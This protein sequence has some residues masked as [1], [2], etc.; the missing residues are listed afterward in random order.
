MREQWIH[1]T[2]AIILTVEREGNMLGRTV[3]VTQVIFITQKCI[4]SSDIWLFA[5]KGVVVHVFMA[6]VQLCVFPADES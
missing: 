6:I 4:T 3:A 2:E 5:A 1:S